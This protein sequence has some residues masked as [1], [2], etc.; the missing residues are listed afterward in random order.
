M[1]NIKNQ[2]S[3]IKMTNQPRMKIKDFLRGK[4]SK[5]VYKNN[6]TSAIFPRPWQ[7]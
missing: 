3:N 7:G 4:N 2:K 5:K 6:A 1:V